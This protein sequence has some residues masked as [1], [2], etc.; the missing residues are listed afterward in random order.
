MS[1]VESLPHGGDVI[2]F[3]G[4]CVLCNGLVD[5]VIRRDRHRRFRYATSPV[6]ERAAH[7][8]KTATPY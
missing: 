2:Y 4:V 6:G 1:E 5:F 3:D 7:A 8:E